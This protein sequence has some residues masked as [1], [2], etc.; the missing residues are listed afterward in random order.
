MI[1]DLTAEPQTVYITYTLYFIPD[2]A[3]QAAMITPIHTQWLDVENGKPYPVFNA[4]R[5]A[6]TKGRFTFPNQA[7]RAY[8][9]DGIQRNRWVADHDGT[10][11]STAGHLHPGGL[12]ND[13]LI[14]RNG[15]TKRV[16]RSRADY[17]EPVGPVS[18]DVAMS[19]T[20]PDWKVDF[21]KGDVIS[22]TATYDTTRASWYEVMGIMTLGITDHQVPGGVDP[23]T[24]PGKIDQTD[25]LTHGRLKENIDVGA[26]EPNPGLHNPIRLR[27][28]PYKDRVVVKNFVYSQGDLSSP[29][30][31]GLPPKV[32]QG[33]S[34][35]FVNRDVPLTAR[36]HTITACKAPCNRIGGIGY[37]LAGG[38]GGFDSGELGYGP[39]IDSALY[40]NGTGSQG[41]VPITA[42]IDTPTAKSN[43]A[44]VP[45]I[46]GVI[47]KSCI[48]TTIYRTPKNLSPGTY[49]YFCRIHPF[50]RGA[51]RV[52]KQ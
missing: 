45:G 17:F 1:H 8:A 40:S 28:G 39:A 16:F 47:A 19:A 24:D 43:C 6:G 33:H 29:G 23:F 2:T 44:S 10:M 51:F 35:T 9:A 30:K 26:G 22:T 13:L 50:M 46:V 49:S 25:H 32:R 31:A 36:F 15:V 48:G 4:L 20:A 42:A 41:T 7:P 11:V 37:P 18:W 21:K 3:P 52:V 12:F 14:T 38:P 34:L 5:H 27:S